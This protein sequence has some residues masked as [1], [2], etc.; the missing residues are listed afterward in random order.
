MRKE[1]DKQDV[2]RFALRLFKLGVLDAGPAERG[3]NG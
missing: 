2:Y 1:G 3:R